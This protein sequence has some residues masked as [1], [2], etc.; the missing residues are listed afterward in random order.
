MAEHMTSGAIPIAYETG[1]PEDGPAVVMLNGLGMQLTQWPAA[2]LDALHGAG[3]RTV[4]IDNR[5]VGLSGR[6]EGR[7]PP[8]PYVQMLLGLVGVSA[9]APYR[10]EDMA[11]DAAS[12]LDDMGLERA[13]ILGLSMGGIIAQVFAARH[14]ART[15]RLALFM[16]TTGRKTLPLPE[17]EGMKILMA[18]GPVPRNPQE[19]TQQMVDRWKWFMTRD[20]G[21]TDTELW[22][23]HE[24][25]VSRGMDRAGWKRQLAAILATGDLRHYSRKIE[26]PTLIIHGTADRLVPPAAGRDVHANIKGSQLAMIE[27]MGH[28]LPPRFLPDLA[29]RVTNHFKGLVP[30]VVI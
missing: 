18:S 23:F 2:F 20:G 12:V 30:G 15:D 1:G 3:F 4:R 28:D 21:M 11:D 27:G 10:L 14:A 17:R 13:H 24:A 25:A 9:G 22:A 29:E 6:V 19:A 26:A 16:T 8:H 7:K 5:D